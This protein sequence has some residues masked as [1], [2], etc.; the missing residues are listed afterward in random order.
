MLG[1]FPDSKLLIASKRKEEFVVN[2]FIFFA[3]KI[4]KKLVNITYKP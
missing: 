4:K 1:S 3:E 2:K